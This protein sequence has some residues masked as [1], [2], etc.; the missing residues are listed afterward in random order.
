MNEYLEAMLERIKTDERV[1]A[2]WEEVDLGPPKLRKIGLAIRDEYYSNFYAHQAKWLRDF[3]PVTY[4]EEVARSPAL[5]FILLA[6]GTLWM[7]EAVPWGSVPEHKPSRAKILL[8]RSQRLKQ[9]WDSVGYS[10]RVEFASL[11]RWCFQFWIHVWAALQP[12]LPGQAYAIYHAAQAYIALVHF[13]T[14][15]NKHSMTPLGWNE[16][17]TVLDEIEHPASIEAWSGAMVEWF[18]RTGREI[19]QKTGWEYPSALE[20]AVLSVAKATEDR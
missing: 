12:M 13:T 16:G 9:R 2:A 14:V 18:Q 3:L 6:N 17:L 7:L 11:D 19:S 20:Q 15:A 8:D 5:T 4:M 1:L 10:P